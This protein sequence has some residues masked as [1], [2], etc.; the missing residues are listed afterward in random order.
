M[1]RQ[2]RV[3]DAKHILILREQ[4]AQETD[5]MLHEVDEGTLSITEQEAILADFISSSNKVFWVVEIQQVIVGFCVGIG[6]IARRNQHNLY[7]VMGILQRYTGQGLG[8]ELLRALENWAQV[9]GFSRLELTV[10]FHNQA[11]R[12]LYLSQGFE[13]EGIKRQS[14]NINGQYVD[15]VYMSKLLA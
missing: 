4:L 9:S 13:E 2:A 12:G 6:S 5:F 11:A 15:E 8:R 14:L 7:C 3:A 10:M 1:I